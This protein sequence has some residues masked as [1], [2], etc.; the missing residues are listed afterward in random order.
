AI[1]DQYGHTVGD[2][3]LRAVAAALAQAVAGNAAILA[4]YGGEEFAIVLR[5]VDAQAAQDIAERV[6][7]DI[8]QHPIVAGQH[9]IDVTIS[10]G[11][12]IVPAHTACEAQDLLRRAD[13]RLYAA[14][15]AGRNR[16][17]ISTYDSGAAS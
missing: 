9:H 12:H 1:N 7:G 15:R 10:I 2:S 17:E 3:C 4:R 11:L 14:K 8:E 6:R 13:A 5:G 16:I